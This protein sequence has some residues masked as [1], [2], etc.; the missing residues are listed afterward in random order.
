MA[1]GADR[2]REGTGLGVAGESEGAMAAS[3]Q[4]PSC[5][6]GTVR[7]AGQGGSPSPGALPRL[8]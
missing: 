8:V 3:V 4:Q 1:T 2:S 5:V 7:I 6:R